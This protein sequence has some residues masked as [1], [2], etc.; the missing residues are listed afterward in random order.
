MS[1]SP[2]RTRNCSITCITDWITC[3]TEYYL[4]KKIKLKHLNNCSCSLIN[5]KMIFVINST[6]DIYPKNVGENFEINADVDSFYFQK[7][8]FKAYFIIFKKII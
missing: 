6:F 3:T 7:H 1:S 2:S 4:K 8:T 5:F